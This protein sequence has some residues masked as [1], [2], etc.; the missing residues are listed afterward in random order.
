MIVSPLRTLSDQ[1]DPK[2]AA[3]LVIDMQND[4]CHPDGVSGKRN[5]KLTMTI[6]MAPRLEAFIKACRGAGMPVIFV[7]TIHYPWTDSPSW[8]R[9]LDKDGG[10]SVCRPGTWGAEFYG[11]IQPAEGEIVITKHRYSAF[12]GTNLDLIL[13][14]TGI[15]SL[16]ISGVGTNVCVESTLRDGYM[17]DY[18]IVMLEDCVGA[19]N[20]ELHQATLKNV[21]LHFGTVTDSNQVEKL[22]KG[23]IDG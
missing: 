4:F 8:V 18:Y 11:G 23:I 15:R 7:K 16:L 22:W 9:R 17:R 1:V 19:T 6:E 13:R 2:V 20:Q 12:L 10:D 3:L 5:R 21:N 14:S